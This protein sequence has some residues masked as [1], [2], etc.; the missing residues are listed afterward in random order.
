M[1]N[2]NTEKWLGVGSVNASHCDLPEF[3][4]ERMLFEFWEIWAHS[5]L[6]QHSTPTA[7]TTSSKLLLVF[8]HHYS[9]ILEV[10]K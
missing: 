5:N 2:A 7:L 1:K 4:L 3:Q 8:H 6:S 9:T 10:G